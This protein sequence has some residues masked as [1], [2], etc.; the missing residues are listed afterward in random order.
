MAPTIVA[1]YVDRSPEHYLSIAV[2]GGNLFGCAFPLLKL[3]KMQ[4]SF[5]HLQ[6]MLSD[7]FNWLWMYIGAA[8]GWLLHMIIPVIII[9]FCIVYDKIRLEFL[10]SEQKKLIEEWGDEVK[11]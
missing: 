5:L 3:F 10:Y 9:K 6:Y 2:F 8:G 4:V 11:S 7:V 1:I